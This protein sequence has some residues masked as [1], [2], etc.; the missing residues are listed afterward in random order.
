M[1]AAILRQQAQT[2][3]AFI[4]IQP[5][6]EQ[7]LGAL[8]AQEVDQWLGSQDEQ[9]L[10][11]RIRGSDL[12]NILRFTDFTPIFSDENRDYAA[13]LHFASAGVLKDGDKYKING[14]NMI[15]EE[16]YLV[17]FPASLLH[18]RVALPFLIKED[19]SLRPCGLKLKETIINYLE[20]VKD[21]NLLAAQRLYEDY[22]EDYDIRRK[23][24]LPPQN[25]ITEELDLKLED[26]GPRAVTEYF[27]DQV[28][29]AYI[30]DIITLMENKP[31]LTGMWRFNLR[32]LS[33]QFTNTD[34]KNSDKY[35]GYS[36]S[37]LNS[38]SQTLIQGN[39]NFAAEYYKDRIRWDNILQLE[40]G[41]V[42]IRPQS[43]AK[44]TNES[45]DS[46]ILSTE[47]TYKSMD[48]KNF[49]GGFLLGPFLSLSYQTEF[50]EPDD[51][52]RYQILRGKG[53]IRLFEGKY[54]KDVY[55][56]LVPELDFTYADASTKYAW[57]FGF[58]V[59]QPVNDKA[60][61]I[62]R[63]MLRNFFVSQNAK[64]NDYAYELELD[65]RLQMEVLRKFSVAPFV[66][67][68]QAKGK[69]TDSVGSN[70]YIGVS[71]SYSRLFKYLSF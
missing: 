40:Y 14:L 17:S 52:P 38:D 61:T 13:G 58:K 2:E 48:I 32:N 41:R 28:R 43:G 44:Y 59:E 16:Y 34:V 70:L 66:N 60:K 55:L 25:E 1:S 6:S 67:Y 36:N 23:Q 19:I 39:L 8:T 33:L 24:T 10:K 27:L 9:I 54:L 35:S 42:T 63:A 68:Y 22:R 53:G 26:I 12:K 47:Y 3:I 7:F 51:T 20:A 62:Y 50:T 71:L 37:R 56:V 5:F 49:A 11:A 64:E 46:I 31:Q 18:E 29:G 21:K 65:A 30:A 69:S 57:E 15:D 45:V 4:K